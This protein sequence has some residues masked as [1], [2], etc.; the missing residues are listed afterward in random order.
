MRRSFNLIPLHLLTA[1]AWCVA[2]NLHAV[3]VG[4]E[5][6]YPSKPIHLIVTTAAGGAGDLVAR[7]VAERLSES[8]RQ[9]VIV[10]NQPAGNGGIAAAQ[11]VR[12]APDGYTLLSLVDST[13]T[14]NPHLYS[15]LQQTP[16]DAN[17]RSTAPPSS[18]GMRSRMML[19]P[20]K[21]A[22][23]ISSR[24]FALSVKAKLAFTELL[25]D[26]IANDADAV[27]ESAFD[28]VSGLRALGESQARVHSHLGNSAAR[29]F[30]GRD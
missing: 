30:G 2:L 10:E 21:R 12:A 26:E 9:P 22:H 7:V 1:L 11:V 14:I 19:T 27:Q 4:A 18:C 28:L 20:Y 17:A 23:S 13:L 24:G 29:Q 16:L 8:M 25:R 15:I 3:S 5:E 6:F